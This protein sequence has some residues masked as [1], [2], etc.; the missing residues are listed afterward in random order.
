MAVTI[1]VKEHI[2]TWALARA[3]YDLTAFSLKYPSLKVE[4]W[5]YGEK[6]PTVKQLEDFSKKVHV[7]FGY[8]FLEEPPS[9]T[10]EFPFFRTGHKTPS[11]KVSPNVYDTILDL[12][13]RQDW[14]RDYL[15]QLDARPLE[16]VGR[17][18]VGTP[19]DQFVHDLRKTLDL[20]AGWTLASP[21]WED[22]LTVLMDAIERVGII[23][24]QN[25][26]VGNNTSRSI[27]VDECRGFVLVDEYAPF[28]FVNNS[29]AKAAQL[30]TLVHELAHV[31]L[32]KSAGFNQDQLLPA[33]DPIE[34]LCDSVAAEFLVPAH[35]LKD[36][37]TDIRD[38]RMLSTRFKVSPV[39]IARR[40]LDLGM[41][42]KALFFEFYNQYMEAVRLKKEQSSGGGD[43]YRTSKRR[44]S[45]TFASYVDSAVK[46]GAITYQDAF[47]L[48]GIFG[49]VY[50]R[51]I[52]DIVIK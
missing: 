23:V 42:S 2:I 14:L 34:S 33:D 11:Y 9:E 32:G 37:W 21:T 6:Q 4:K 20:R 16:Y 5:L 29:D 8:L 10:I 38:I 36:V 27:P 26:V 22:T 51:F 28:L 47:K 25:G 15:Q 44:V 18:D 49:D 52:R 1:P 46:S 19:V 17:F 43:F 40:A 45:P 50:T 13:R 41:V 12:S 39:V 30:F 3:G 31:W 48:T 7:P 24:I 35:L